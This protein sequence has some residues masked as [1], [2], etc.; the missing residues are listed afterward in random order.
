MT[1]KKYRTAK[2]AGGIH[3]GFQ[4]PVSCSLVSSETY[5]AE[6]GLGNSNPGYQS[7]VLTGSC[8]TVLSE[9][10]APAAIP[11]EADVGNSNPDYS[12]LF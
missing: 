9:L 8:P 3:I 7:P 10:E 5:A 4:C 1:C 11:V 12:L 6:A 2:K